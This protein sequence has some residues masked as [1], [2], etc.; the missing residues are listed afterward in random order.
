[1]Q[2]RAIRLLG[3]NVLMKQ[4]NAAELLL[5]YYLMIA[6]LV[7]IKIGLKIKLQLFMCRISES[8]LKMAKVL[9]RKAIQK[10]L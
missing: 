8:V 9:H 2:Y 4:F 1:M 3:A 7:G 10:A 5:V 6:V